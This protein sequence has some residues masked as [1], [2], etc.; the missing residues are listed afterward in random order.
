MR[1]S[2]RSV[3]AISRRAGSAPSSAA[4]SVVRQ[5]RAAQREAAV[6]SA[7]AAGDLARLVQAHAHAALGERQR[8]RAAGDAA[9]DDG[10]VGASVEAR[11]AAARAGLV[12]PV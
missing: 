8:A 7:R 11:R 4:R 6:A 2:A 9:A 5:R 3:S 12:E 1:S 10:D